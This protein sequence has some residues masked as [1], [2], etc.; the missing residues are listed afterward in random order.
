V[1]RKGKESRPASSEQPL[2]WG[3]RLFI[4]GSSVLF[5]GLAGSIMLW[6]P[7]HA[8]FVSALVIFGLAGFSF[9]LSGRR[10]RTP[11]L[12]KASLPAMTPPD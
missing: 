7:E 4:G 3:L 10:A 2:P 11:C 12:P 6:F 1:G 9:L 8:F 5:L